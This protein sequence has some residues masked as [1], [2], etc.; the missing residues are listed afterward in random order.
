MTSRSPHVLVLGLNGSLT[1]VDAYL[2]PFARRG[3]AVTWVA[4]APR[5]PAFRRPGV[6]VIDAEQRAVAALDPALLRVLDARH[7]AHPI[8]A[9][10]SFVEEWVPAAARLARRYRVAGANPLRCALRTTDKLAMRRT[11]AAAGLAVPAFAMAHDAGEALRRACQVGFPCVV[12]PRR[13]SGSRGVRV[14]H[15][16]GEVAD[17]FGWTSRVSRDEG[18]PADVLVEEYVEGTEYSAEIAVSHGEV[19]FAGFTEKQLIGGDFRDEAGHVHP[20]ILPA[21]VAAAARCL[22]DA[23]VRA[24]G[25]RAGGCHLEFKR[26]AAADR[27]V[28]MEIASRLGGAAIPELVHLA[29]GVDLLDLVAGAHLGEP[30]PAEMR[31]TRSA[32]AGIR[33][34]TATAPSVVTGA[35]VA[36][37]AAIPGVLHAAVVQPPGATVGPTTSGGTRVALV[38]GRHRDH[39]RLVAGL[40]LA[41]SRIGEAILRPVAGPAPVNGPPFATPLAG[42]LACAPMS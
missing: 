23:A 21:G 5:S 20:A 17:T 18:G 19:V 15:A 26:D 10:V 8:A 3:C 29:T 32:F 34:V 12:K 6:R 30:A 11:L 38:V 16:A 1:P 27:L 9:V 24:T 2:A 7:A 36:S 39:D 13:S 41:A 42:E 37:V 31:A 25:V 28:V 14:V 22:V 35:A 33:F 4:T 40:T